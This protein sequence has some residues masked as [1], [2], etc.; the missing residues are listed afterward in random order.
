MRMKIALISDVHGNLPALRAV[1]QRLEGLKPDLTLCLGD[2]VGYGP[3]PTACIRLVREMGF[4]CV[5]GNHDAAVCGKLALSAFREPNRSL[6]QWTSDTLV[7]EDTAWLRSLPLIRTSESAAEDTGGAWVMCHATPMHPERWERLDSAITC[8]K[9]LASVPQRF[10]F[11]GHTH[12]P[13]VVADELG[14]FGLEPGYR[15]WINPGA[16][17][18]SRD[19]DPRACFGLLDTDASSYVHHRVSYDTNLTLAAF[20]EIGIDPPV[21]R[22]LLNLK[23]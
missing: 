6:L 11:A 14:V 13:S 3:E 4:P 5:L 8:R 16:V 22:K 21:A 23:H 20:H 15:Y 19:G 10:V 2:L 12:V 1:L 9:V 17:G 18:Q 7:E